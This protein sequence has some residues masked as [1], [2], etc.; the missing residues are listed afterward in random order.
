MTDKDDQQTAVATDQSP[1]VYDSKGSLTV[2]KQRLSYQASAGW[3]A[4]FKAE[5]KSAEMFH[6]YYRLGDKNAQARPLTFVFNGG[7]GAASAYLHVGAVGPV[8]VEA[9]KDGTLPPAPA[10]LVQN[11]ESWLPFTDLVFIDPI[12][13]GLSRTIKDNGKDGGEKSDDETYYWDVAKDLESLCEFI[14]SFLSKHGRWRSPIYIAGESYGGYRS[15]RLARMLQEK[16]VGLS[17]AILISPVLE[18]DHFL[19]SRFNTQSVAVRLPTYA[20]AARHHGKSE[21]TA[22]RESLSAFL[23]RA[24]TYALGEYLTSFTMGTRLSAAERKKQVAMLSEWIGLSPEVLKRHDGRPSI[25]TFSRELLRDQG[26]ILGLYDASYAIDD[27]L[28]AADTFAGADPTLAGLDRLY[29]AGTNAH[30]RENLGVDV[31]QQYKLLS[32]DVNRKWQWANKEAGDLTPP[33]AAEDLAV[34]LSMNPD[35]KLMVVHGLYDL[36]TPYMDSK[37]FVEQLAQSSPM[38]AAIDFKTYEG[39]H[40]FYMWEKSR[41]AFTKDVQA[42][43]GA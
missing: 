6:T 23:N 42:L 19:A 10:K 20:A 17:G 35:M 9:N 24:E 12:G 8:R 38:A 33:G 40:M 2:D 22:P 11:K 27:P 3:Q 15:A 43:F 37:Y 18:W 5:K 31:E 39:G 21:R 4:L 7:P 1:K 32:M 16:G 25:M 34:G 29:V 26:K 14:S 36:V 13:T 41:V 28:P 30:L